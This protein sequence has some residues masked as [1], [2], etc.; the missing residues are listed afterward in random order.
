MQVRAINKYARISPKKARDVAREIQGLPV[1]DALDALTY[2]PKKAAY[3]IGKTLKSAVANAENNHELVADTLVVK[4][5]HVT[6]GPT[7]RRFKPRA[8][9]SASAIRK[10]TSHIYITLAEG[11]EEPSKGKG[12]KSRA[13]KKAA[14]KQAKKKSAPAKSE[15]DSAAGG[16]TD[17]DLGKVY[18]SAPEQVDDLKKISGVGPALEE[19]L[20]NYGVYTYQQIIDWNSENILAFDE[21]LAFKG[22]I[23]RDDWQEQAKTLQAE[24]GGEA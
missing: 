19:K 23:E 15:D 16:T 5:A 10:R 6:D 12:Q 18:D 22:R 8:R 14:P 11:E 13:A 1:S 2:T 24:K 3:L 9:G 20:N 21:L 17:K 7:F 4:E